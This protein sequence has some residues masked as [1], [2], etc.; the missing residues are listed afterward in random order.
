M[1][2]ELMISTL[3]HFAKHPPSGDNL[4][5]WQETLNLEESILMLLAIQMDCESYDALIEELIQISLTGII[6]GDA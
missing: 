4:D 6:E 1:G 2:L 3:K 5:E